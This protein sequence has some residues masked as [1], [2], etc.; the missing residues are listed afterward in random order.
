MGGGGG[1]GVCVK[2]GVAKTEQ[3]H[4]DLQ[5]DGQ[6]TRE[7]Y[8]QPLYTE[9]V[10]HLWMC[11]EYINEGPSFL[12]NN[13]SSPG[14]NVFPVQSL[15]TFTMNPIS[16]KK[17]EETVYLHEKK[18]FF[19]SRVFLSI[20]IFP[21]KPFCLNTSYFYLAWVFVITLSHERYSFIW[22]SAGRDW[23]SAQY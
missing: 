17:L 23:Q 7:W 20:Y 9:W 1:V 15:I 21:G 12:T 16:K 8:H 6:P 19:S 2:L 14:A 13:L 11:L 5:M 22:C 3:T 18:H 4:Q 10:E